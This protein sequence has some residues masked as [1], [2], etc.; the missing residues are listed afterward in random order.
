VLA[1]GA[2]GARELAAALLSRLPAAVWK[3]LPV[4]LAVR[5][6]TWASHRAEL[7]EAAVPELAG[8]RQGGAAAGHS[9]HGKV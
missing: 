7:P 1:N 6:K 9:S 3:A 5:A 8:L 4:G 2:G